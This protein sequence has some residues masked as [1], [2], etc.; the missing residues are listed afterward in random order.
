MAVNL[1]NEIGAKSVLSDIVIDAF[2]QASQDNRCKG[3][4]CRSIYKWIADIE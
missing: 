1:G 3:K 4:D 2:E